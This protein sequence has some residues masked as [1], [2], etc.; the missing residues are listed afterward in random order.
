M[1]PARSLGPALA[2]VQ[3]HD[4]WIYLVG[5]VLGAAVG[6]LIY[7]MVRGEHPDTGSGRASPR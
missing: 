7:Q 3:W 2:A 6:A 1:N 4:C 5:P